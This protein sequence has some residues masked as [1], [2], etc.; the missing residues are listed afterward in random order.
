MKEENINLENWPDFMDS[1]YK[2]LGISPADALYLNTL[3]MQLLKIKEK[4]IRNK[5]LEKV[6]IEDSSYVHDK[7][8]DMVTDTSY[9]NIVANAEKIANRLGFNLHKLKRKSNT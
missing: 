4:Y 3:T 9:E 6:H 5:T 8:I 7:L 2:K 1:E